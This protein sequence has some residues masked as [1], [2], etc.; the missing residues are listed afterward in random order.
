MKKLAKKL[1]TLL[2][3]SLCIITFPFNV[4]H[5]ESSTEDVETSEYVEDGDSQI[6]S[7]DF[8][9][10]E[11]DE[12]DAMVSI[13][14]IYVDDTGVEEVIKTGHGFFVGDKDKDV[15]L[16]TC[17]HMV[18]MTQDE[19]NAIAAKHEVEVS[20]I[21]TKIK[22]FLKNDV[23]VE[24]ALENSSESMDFAIVKPA[25]ELTGCTTLRICEDANINS[26]GS[27][28]YSYSFAVVATDTDVSQ[29][30]SKV[31]G[32]IE[33]WADIN[34]AHYYK[35]NVSNIPQVG[36][37]IFNENGEVIGIN[38]QSMVMSDGYYSALQINEVIEVMK[39]LGLEYNPEIIV[40]IASAEAILTEFSELQK[41][42][43]TTE[44]WAY[45]EEKQILLNELLASIED[46]DIDYYTQDEL[47]TAI[48]ELRG[49]IDG[50]AK[51]E[52][53]VSKVKKIAIIIGAVLLVVIL[54]L[55]I[56]VIVNKCKY[57]KKLR[58]EKTT[59]QSAMETLKL[60]GRITPGSLYNN[61]SGLP[62]NRSLDNT[63]YT[64]ENLSAETTVLSLNGNN[65]GASLH[66]NDISLSQNITYPKLT[67]LKTG[68]SVIINK[69][70]FVIG[71]APELVDYCVR[72][73]SGIS[74]KHICIMR[75]E[76][77]YYIQ[78]L[79][80]TNGT[81]VNDMRVTNDRYIKLV[82]GSII[83]IAE[84]EFEFTID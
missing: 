36:Y 12:K 62:T 8:D 76:D 15:Y 21:S 48:N 19:K 53:S 73:N 37:P 20:N 42:T 13:S 50:L 45:V 1:T 57:K 25:T 83:K 78:D 11:Y 4:A 77:G 3:V 80:T 40:D 39:I 51:K 38:T 6:S 27:A 24:A 31:E 75:L 7:Y 52:V 34:S 26:N 33:D 59:K 71:K 30:A 41:D 9:D 58:E 47:N 79:N 5:A 28:V 81:Y 67:R 61:A 63:A 70:T 74:R 69:N 68:E 16:I 60:S 46:G 35:Y 64:G 65:M 82:N 10:S 22:I 2:F 32:R 72:Y 55:I 66:F 29:E 54:I 56:I 43:Y 18:S 17:H 84:E 49:A 23:T 14:L 44:T